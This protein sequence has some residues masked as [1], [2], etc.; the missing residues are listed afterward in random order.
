MRQS[1]VNLM[2]PEIVDIEE[3]GTRNT[4]LTIWDLQKDLLKQRMDEVVPI[5]DGLVAKANVAIRNASEIPIGSRVENEATEL[6]A[7]FC[8]EGSLAA[9]IF[10]VSIERGFSWVNYAPV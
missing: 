9:W 8:P 3:K 4:A 6:S 5:Y 1:M 2:V 10:L 7:T